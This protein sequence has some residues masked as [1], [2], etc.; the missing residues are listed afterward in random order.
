LYVVIGDNFMDENGVI[1]ET[2]SLVGA[3]RKLPLST[4]V[5]A[6]ESITFLRLVQERYGALPNF[7]FRVT[8]I[9]REI[10]TPNNPRRQVLTVTAVSWFGWKE[11]KCGRGNALRNRYHL[12]IDPT[13]FNGDMVKDNTFT[14][15]MEWA[16]DI[17]AFCVEQG[18]DLKPTQGAVGR[19]ALRDPRFYPRPRR[20]VPRATNEKVRAH[21]P[22]N[23]YQ[24]GQEP[25]PEIRYDATYLDQ[26]KAH[27][28]HAK[29]AALPDSGS[30]YGYGQ[31]RKDSLA[32]PWRKGARVRSFLASGFTG[33][34]ACQLW[35]PVDRRGETQFVPKY[36]QAYSTK[37]QPA[38]VPVF[39]FTE[40]IPLLDSLG[41]RIQSI[42]SAWGST[43]RDVGISTYARWAIAELGDK[44]P[45]WKKRILL[46]PY[47][48]L[49]T[50]VRK[51]TVGYHQ[52]K[53]GVAHT[54]RSKSGVELD[55]SLHQSSK[56]SEPSTN[57][58]LHRAL[59]EAS[60]RAETLMFANELQAAGHNVLCI[61]VDAVIVE[62]DSDLPLPALMTPWRE[63][64]ALTRLRF[65]SDS[66]FV[67][68][69]IEKL[70]GL[71]G[72]QRK[73]HLGPGGLRGA[74]RLGTAQDR[75]ARKL[76]A[77]ADFKI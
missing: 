68:N 32:K 42:F 37:S 61:Y 7:N 72:E 54:L 13:S 41:V 36:L 56:L 70:P 30:L 60:N 23:H 3:L 62:D 28:F 8:P 38:N 5:Y 64:A 66:Q 55:V 52:S 47:G 17:R 63:D 44:P 12:L 22:G 77:A 26:S 71:T 65:L 27:H 35:W 34:L 39:I 67:S 43:E 9:E 4:V 59:I 24:L 14:A 19:Q 29:E 11:S 74:P 18:W 10:F 20:K 76:A 16:R 46:A 58:V 45:L 2:S 75:F 40:D 57:N 50:G 33:M 69:E 49:A 51:Q 53:R 73:R 6:G 21:L 31:F 48:A 1:G 15:H 25:D